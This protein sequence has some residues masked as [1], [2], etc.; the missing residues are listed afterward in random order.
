M[1]D[2][3]QLK[4]WIETVRQHMP[5]L[6]K[7]QAVVLA[8]WS[9]GIVVMQSCGLTTVTAFLAKLLECKEATMRQRLREWYWAQ[10]DK[11]GEKRRELDVTLC[12]APLLRWVLSWWPANEKRIALAMD[13]TTL[14]DR[15]VVLAVSV[16]Y[17]GCALPV[18]W[19]VLKGNAKDAWKPYWLALLAHIKDSI[20]HDWFV[21]VTADR[22]L[23]ARW[24]YRAIVKNHW[25]PFLRINLGAK[26]R[27]E[28]TH[29]FRWLSQFMPDP[30]AH[31]ARR[32]T[33]FKS[34][35]L[36]CTLLACWGEEHA[37]PWVILT[38]VVPEQADA[39][40]YSL[41]PWIECGFKQ[42][43]RSGWRWHRSRM[44]DP[45]RATRLWLAIAVATLWCVSVGGEVD[46]TCPASTLDTLPETHVARR[47]ATGHTRLRRLSCMRQGIIA[48]LVALIT[49][50]MLPL[51]RFLPE[52]WPS[53]SV[54]NDTS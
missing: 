46:A 52:P 27:P 2:F 38:D 23:Y 31:W 5:L 12:F 22:G 44:T 47:L 42:T 53:S 17:R 34:N 29:T 41:R 1:D 16:V 7:P 36:D 24:L 50:Q 32:V 15:L 26:C 6:S 48:I 21:L 13:A 10:E 45:Q 25:H 40:W 19:I 8:L 20:P 51:G 49:D 43:K 30:G 35:P 37:E 33:C 54:V 14:A 18:A 9:F 4:S 11:Q 28:G 3:E 39:L